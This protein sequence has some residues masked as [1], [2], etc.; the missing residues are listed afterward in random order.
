M[1]TN[2]IMNTLCELSTAHTVLGII[3]GMPVG[4]LLMYLVNSILIKKSR[5]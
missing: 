2:L 5:E 1:D 4:V 3:F